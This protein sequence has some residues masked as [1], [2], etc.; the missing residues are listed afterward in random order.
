MFNKPLGL[1]KRVLFAIVF[2]AIIS[3]FSLCSFSA[4]FSGMIT[5]S[6]RGLTETREAE[7]SMRFTKKRDK[8]KRDKKET[9]KND[10]KMKHPQIIT[11]KK[12]R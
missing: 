12:V 10:T 6:P 1:R 3:Y 9:K 2:F 5:R 8:K 7:S 11:Y 4:A